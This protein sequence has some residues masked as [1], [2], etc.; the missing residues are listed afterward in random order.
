MIKKLVWNDVKQNKLLAGATVFFMGVS[1]MLFALTA[2]LFFHLMGAIDDLMDRAKVPDY[3]QMHTEGGILQGQ[4]GAAM[5]RNATMR[6]EL[7]SFVSTHGEV[8]KWQ[9]CGFLNLDNSQIVLGGRCLA[10]STQDNGCSV[11]GEHFDYLLDTENEMPEVLPGEVYVPVCYRA[12]YDL[13]IG[14]TMEIGSQKFVIAGFIRDAQMNSMM[15]SSKRFLVNEMDYEKIKRSGNARE[16]YLIEFLLHEG[17]D[18]S[19]FGTAYAAEG[20]PANGPAVTRLLVR[21]MNALSDG[22]MIAVFFLVSVITLLVSLLC[23]RFILSLQMERDRK[24]V[25][26]LKALGIGKEEIRRIYF[27]KYFL[28]SVCGGLSGLL[29]AFVLKSPLA[30][31]MKELYGVSEG[32]WQTAALSLAAVFFTEGVILLSVLRSLKRMD[33]LTVL[34]ALLLSEERQNSRGRYGIIGLVAASCTFLIFISQSLYSTMA[35]PGFATYM[36]IGDGEIRMDVRQT[37]DIPVTTER[38]AFA[39]A[40]DAEVEKYAVLCTRSCAAVLPD[41]QMVNFTVETGNHNIFPVNCLEGRLPENKKEIA[42]SAMNAEELG[43]SVGDTLRLATEGRDIEYC[44]CGIYSD[45]TNGGKTAKTCFADDRA[46]AVWSVVYVSLKKPGKKEEWMERYARMGADV[47]DIADYVEETYGQTLRQLHLASRA[48]TVLAMLVIAV[49]VMLFMRLIVERNR[50][51]ISL[52]KALGFTSK[53]IKRIYFAKGLLPAAAGAA[54]GLLAGN[55]LGEGLCGMILKSFGAEG[56]HFV[57]SWELLV[58]I[59]AAVLGASVPALLA[60]IAEIGRI[61]AYECCNR[62]E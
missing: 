5:E 28:F 31:Q 33:G 40:E 15:A 52:H 25:G 36:G 32:R 39:L 48:A 29:A 8:D 17:A 45:I 27:A 26:M 23:I 20:L 55:L 4:D 51:T 6:S 11:Q 58:G 59:P 10:D 60:G 16:E 53:D 54:A 3:M 47:I 37:E 12:M 21:M 42:L 18:I 61:K 30:G 56:F 19:A 57:I 62:R 1:A 22:T 49:V 24:E 44:V 38:I 14:D 9:I 34:E 50:Y 41:G 7:R 35:D 43:L 13:A 2:L 46:P